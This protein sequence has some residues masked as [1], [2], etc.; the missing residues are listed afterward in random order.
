MQAGRGPGGEALMEL[1]LL[2][3][4]AWYAIKLLNFL[5]GAAFCWWLTR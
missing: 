5:A 1:I 4:V 3:I 2:L